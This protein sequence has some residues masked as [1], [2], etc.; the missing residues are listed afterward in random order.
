MSQCARRRFFGW[1]GID[2]G[3]FWKLFLLLGFSVRNGGRSPRFFDLDARHAHGQ[4]AVYRKA[5]NEES[6]SARHG[7]FFST[8]IAN[9]V[10]PSTF[11]RSITPTTLPWCA[12]SSAVITRFTS[13]VVAR[14]ARN[15][16]ARPSRAMGL[17]L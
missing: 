14:A 16:L 7:Y 17:S 10:M 1:R 3:G 11:A 5:Q 15:S 2:L 8:L 12:S 4:S 6:R 13:L 9:F